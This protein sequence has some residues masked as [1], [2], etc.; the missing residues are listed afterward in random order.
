LKHCKNTIKCHVWL[1][2]WSFFTYNLA[3]NILRMFVWRLYGLSPTLPFFSTRSLLGTKRENKK[4]SKQESNVCTRSRCSNK[5]TILHHITHHLLQLLIMH[6]CTTATYRPP[7]SHTLKE[8]TRVFDHQ[9]NKR[10]IRAKASKVKKN[11][12]SC[13]KSM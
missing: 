7:P 11:F 2:S 5:V 12:C 10:A 4:K 8:V 1:I 3:S 9:Q 13:C 6:F